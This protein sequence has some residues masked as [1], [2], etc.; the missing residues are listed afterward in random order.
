MEAPSLFP[1]EKPL[2]I[3]ESVQPEMEGEEFRS[4]YSPPDVLKK[5]GFIDRIPSNW[6]I[7]IDPENPDKIIAVSNKTNEKFE[8][9]M[10]DFNT[11]LRGF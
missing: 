1:V 4:T 7:R 10:K 9:V 8:G 3:T 11:L 2:E 5:D 6:D